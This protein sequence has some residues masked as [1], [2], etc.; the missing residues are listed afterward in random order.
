MSRQDRTQPT[1]TL[2]GVRI[3]AFTQFLLGPAGVQYL[4]DLGADVIKVENPQRGAW[5]RSWAGGDTFINGV[6]AFFLMS[7]RNVR[8]VGLDLKRPEGRDAALR[9]IETADVVVENFRP[10]VMEALGLGY[11]DV[12]ERR[13][14]LIYASGSGYG[15]TSPYRSLPGQ[16]LLI[17]ALTGLPMVTGCAGQSPVPAGAPVVDQHA[18]A[19]LAMGILAALVHRE[20]TGEGQRVE[21]N[22]IQA[23]LDLQQEPVV[24]H[25]NGTRIAATQERLGSAFHAAPYGLYPTRDGYV[26]ISLSSV[27]ALRAALGGAEALAPYE[28]PAIA[29][30]QRDEVYRALASVIVEWSTRELLERLRAEAIWCSPVNDYDAV[31]A[32]D[33]VRS[34]DPVLEIDHPEAGMVKLLPHPISYSRADTGVR[35]PPPALGEHTAPVLSELGYSEA[36]LARMTEEGVAR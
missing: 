31:F 13:E 34:V 15:S 4:S 19:L 29:L 5:E 6:S 32:D 24:Y 22:M 27:A 35:S 2:E 26:A 1:R 33:S 3:V 7:H 14:G 8:S 21:V 18:A 28:D 9:L 23:A 11:D 12:R 17:Q 36:E 20:R 16:D 10:G 25:L 30:A